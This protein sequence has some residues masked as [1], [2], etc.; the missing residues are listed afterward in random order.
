MIH[1]TYYSR[2]NINYR[3]CPVILTVYDMIHEKFKE[4]F[5]NS[6]NTINIKKIAINRADHI[7]CQ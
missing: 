2:I 1:E 6:D 3:R 4:D 7:I 5:S